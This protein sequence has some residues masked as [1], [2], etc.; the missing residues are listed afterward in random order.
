MGYQHLLRSLEYWDDIAIAK[1]ETAIL[2]K[3]GLDFG[4]GPEPLSG[5]LPLH[6]SRVKPTA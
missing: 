4:I 3:L 1:A 6:I 2:L 5:M